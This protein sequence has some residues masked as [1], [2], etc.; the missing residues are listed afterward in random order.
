MYT[1][2]H[3]E[4]INFVKV[5][6]KNMHLINDNI[7][8]L[9]AL[10]KKYKVNKLYAFG[11]VLTIDFNEQSDVDILVNFN[12]E[13]N[14]RNYADNFFDFYNALKALFG[15]EVDLVDELSVKNPYFKEELEATKYLIYG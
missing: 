9:V 3:K 8:N 13:I 7:H 15:R 10:C 1:H 5:E 6:N 2:V 14:Y 11:S 4:N 12:S